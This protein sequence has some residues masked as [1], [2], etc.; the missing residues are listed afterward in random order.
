MLKVGDK[1][2]LSFEVCD[3]MAIPRKYGNVIVSI[4]KVNKGYV[5]VCNGDWLVNDDL[6][7]PATP[8][9]VALI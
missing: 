5:T 7:I 2:F 8:L 3:T 4:S 1:I 6:L 9:I